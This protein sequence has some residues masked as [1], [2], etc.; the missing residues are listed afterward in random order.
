MTGAPLLRGEIAS[1]GS[2]DRR[3]RRAP[4]PDA[5]DLVDA[6]GYSLRQLAEVIHLIDHGVS[7][8]RHY[9]GHGALDRVAIEDVHLIALRVLSKRHLVHLPA[10]AADA[11]S[12]NPGEDEITCFRP[13]S[14]QVHGTERAQADAAECMLQLYVIRVTEVPLG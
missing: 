3:Q 7:D 1:C 13:S 5:A 2:D 12:A 8:R 14:P 9:R 6:D 11:G 10:I 4:A